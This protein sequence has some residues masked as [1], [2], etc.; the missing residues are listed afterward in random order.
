MYTTTSTNGL[1]GADPAVYNV[2]VLLSLAL[3]VFIIASVWR[4]FKKAGKPG[5][6]AL[7][8]FYNTWVLV[9]VAK[10]SAVW[11]VLTFIPIVSIVALVVIYNGVSKAF[12]K[13]VGTT[14]LMVF[15]PYVMFPYL[16]FGK[17]QYVGASQD[18]LA[19]TGVTGGSA[20]RA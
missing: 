2:I 9:E 13:G 11:F 4:L 20:P 19:Q 6:A 18:N 12:G 15:F 17:A 8:P 3:I 1:G 5:W 16:A 10:L 7:V 14:V